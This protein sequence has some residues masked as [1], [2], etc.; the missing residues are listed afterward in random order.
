[1]SGIGSSGQPSRCTAD[2]GS[3]LLP[4]PVVAA[5]GVGVIVGDIVAT[6]NMAAFPM[7]AKT[8]SDLISGSLMLYLSAY[9]HIGFNFLFKQAHINK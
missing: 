5:A 9:R 3:P 4:I 1:M 8:G 2:M 7:T 6:T